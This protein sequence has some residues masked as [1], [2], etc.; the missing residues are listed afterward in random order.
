MDAPAHAGADLDDPS[1][2]ALLDVLDTCSPE[3]TEVEVS[4]A[5]IDAVSVKTGLTLQQV[6]DLLEHVP[7]PL[8]IG[9]IAAAASL[10]PDPASRCSGVR[11]RMVQDS[12]RCSSDIKAA[13]D[14]G[15]DFAATVPLSRL[16]DLAVV[17]IDAEDHLAEKLSAPVLLQAVKNLYAETPEDNFCTTIPAFV[18]LLVYS[19]AHSN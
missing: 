4:L 15:D 3:D 9:A 17:A 1:A 19:H 18:S 7:P 12:L 11:C 10:N 13:L 16:Q 14:D 2:A 5:V 8:R 6:R